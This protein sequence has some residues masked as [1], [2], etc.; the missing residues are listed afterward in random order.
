[1]WFRLV[2]PVLVLGIAA[3]MPLPAASQGSSDPEL[4]ELEVEYVY[5][6]NRGPKMGYTKP[7][8]FNPI[9]DPLYR[10]GYKNYRPI[11]VPQE[12]KTVDA[13]TRLVLAVLAHG[14]E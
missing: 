1:M 3:A 12:L 14:A 11:G 5:G 2:V 13:M 10:A 7:E 8:V 4:F 9:T 6:R